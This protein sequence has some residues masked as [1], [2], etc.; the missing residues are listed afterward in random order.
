MSKNESFFTRLKLGLKDLKTL[1][2][3]RNI[4]SYSSLHKAFKK[5]KLRKTKFEKAYYRINRFMVS[6]DSK[7]ITDLVQFRKYVKDTLKKVDL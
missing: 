1:W 5:G 3:D 7:H 4:P 2:A 6:K